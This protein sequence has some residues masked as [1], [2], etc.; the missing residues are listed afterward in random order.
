MQRVHHFVALVLGVLLVVVG[1]VVVTPAGAAQA[2]APLTGRYTPVETSRVYAGSVG[3]KP[4]VVPIS[5]KAGVPSNARAVVLNVEVKS[6][7]AAGYVRVTPAGSDP[8]VVTQAFTRG[9]SIS[10]LTT[11][12]LSGGRVQVKLSAG[13]AQV[14]FDVSGYYADGRGST[15]T[16]VT[17]S[18][19]FGA[20]V[21]TDP[22][23]VPLTGPDAAGVPSDATAVAVN[24][25]VQSQTADGYVRVTS[26]GHDAQVAAQV[27]RADTPVSNLVIVG[28]SGGAAQVKV[29]AGTATVY[30]DVTGYYSS[31]TSGSVFVPIDTVRAYS[32]DLGTAASPIRLSGTAGVPGT[33]TA[34]VATAQVTHPSATGYLRLTPAGQDPQVATQNYRAG[35]SVAALTMPK[36]TGTTVDRRVQAKVRS[37]T[38]HLY[39]DVSGYF[40]DGSSGSGIGADISYPQ[41]STPSTWPQDQSFAVV[42]VNGG[43]TTES[44]DCFNQ[45]LA[46]AL[47]SHG[48]TSQPKVQLYVNTA[49]PGALASVWPKSNTIPKGPK[50]VNPYGNCTGGYDKACSFMYGYTRA[51]ED[52]QKRNVPNASKY[53][54][55]L[56]VEIGG[57]TGATWQSDKL[58]NRADLEGMV[59]YFTS[60]SAKV[61]IYSTRYQLGLVTGTIPSTSSLYGLPSWV[62][63][64]GSSMAEA[65]ATC[66]S[67]PLTSGSTVVMTQYEIGAI[68]RNVSC[69]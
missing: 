67:A 15:Y 25:G 41:C 61:G 17:N 69:V 5:G 31:A 21:G 55:W 34:V 19:V 49:N 45:Q 28:L 13:A 4:T 36:V 6:P 62:P 54:W 8:Q 51:Y 35:Q 26:A 20:T 18:R 68:D 22:T 27:Y 42:G 63:T 65:Q 23:E 2:A 50:V 53:R 7:T 14:Y 9:G 1:L 64:G 48:G 12:K 60:V 30:M 16:P 66:S 56:D 57:P 32:G 44:N 58:Q 59:E 10:N 11:V 38:A 47:T 52:V 33:A 29:S 37:G 40:L 43:R 3:T 39:L 24:V 46:W